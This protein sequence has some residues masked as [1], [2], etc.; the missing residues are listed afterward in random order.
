MEPLEQDVI[1]SRIRGLQA[2]AG[3]YSATMKLAYQ[4]ACEDC[5]KVVREPLRS[6]GED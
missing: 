6:V 5:L 4:E 3:N 2:V 1:E